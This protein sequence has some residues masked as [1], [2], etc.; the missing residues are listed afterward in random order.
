MKNITKSLSSLLVIGALAVPA[1]ASAEDPKAPEAP[2]P[3]GHHV[4]PA[5]D[6]AAK[7]K[8]IKKAGSKHDT[9]KP[10]TEKAPQ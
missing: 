2:P 7:H 9:S 1:F 8:E 6:P 3:P 5:K 4:K 10:D